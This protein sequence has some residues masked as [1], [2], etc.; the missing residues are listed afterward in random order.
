MLIPRQIEYW[1]WLGKHLNL[2]IVGYCTRWRFIRIW[3]TARQLGLHCP[4]YRK[5]KNLLVQVQHLSTRLITDLRNLSYNERLPSLRLWT[6]E[7]GR[8]RADLSE[9]FK[10]KSWLL[11]SISLNTYFDLNVD[12]PTRGHSWKIAKISQLDISKYFFSERVVQRW[13]Q[14]S[15][16]NDQAT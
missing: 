9:A 10:M 4:H 16:E 8:N 6:S 3:S 7:E 5:D 12:N 1:V 15:Q 13:N 14:L 11:S 2:G